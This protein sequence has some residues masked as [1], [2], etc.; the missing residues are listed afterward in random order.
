V[1]AEVTKHILSC[2]AWKLNWLADKYDRID[3]SGAK[4]L[5]MEEYDSCTNEVRQ[6]NRGG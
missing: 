5:W 6:R 1:I 3:E 4:K 2:R